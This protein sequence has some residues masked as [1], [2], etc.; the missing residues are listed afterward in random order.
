MNKLHYD[1]K[2]YWQKE[3]SEILSWLLMELQW[4]DSYA[5][6]KHEYSLMICINQSFMAVPMIGGLFLK[7]W[8]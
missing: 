8:G 1:L 6:K 2:D 4:I 5:Q 3:N 7:T